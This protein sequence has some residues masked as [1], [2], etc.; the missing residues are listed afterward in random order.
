MDSHSP[1]PPRRRTRSRANQYRSQVRGNGVGVAEFSHMALWATAVLAGMVT[2]MLT[3]RAPF[4][5]ALM[6]RVGLG[7]T[8]DGGDAERPSREESLPLLAH[9]I[10]GSSKSAVAEVFG[11]PRSALI[12]GVPAV[13]PGRP[14]YWQADTWY[15]PL[16]KNDC[17]AMAIEFANESA[18]YVEFFRAP[19]V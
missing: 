18:R 7:P 3:A 19:K 6:K 5:R 1:M 14:P 11:P 8:R 13:G 10:V 12:H 16:P 15:Y 2:A 17:L 9:A 4:F